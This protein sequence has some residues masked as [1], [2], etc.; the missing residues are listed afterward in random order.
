MDY[1][2]RAASSRFMFVK[3]NLQLPQL[4]HCCFFCEAPEMFCELRK[5]QPSFHQHG[6]EQTTTEFFTFG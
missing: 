4:L 1:A 5:L 3:S 2:G 6:D